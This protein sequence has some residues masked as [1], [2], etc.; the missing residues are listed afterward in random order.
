M[1]L[2]SISSL[3]LFSILLLQGCSGLKPYPQQKTKN[4]NISTEV[5]S[6]S[7]FSSVNAEVDFYTLDDYCAKSY[8]GTL[9]L[10]KEAIASG[11][12]TNQQ[13]ELSFIFANSSFLGA[14]NS[15][16]SFPVYIKARKGFHYDF[17]VSY[18]DNIYNVILYETNTKTRKRRE[19][20]TQEDVNCKKR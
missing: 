18:K 6:G 12:K 13:M 16:M 7:F 1:R 10:D 4:I 9:K 3:V 19:L 15:S 11:V 20:D 2:Q 14:S 5:D 8:Q 17:V